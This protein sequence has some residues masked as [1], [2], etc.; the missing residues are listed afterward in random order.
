MLVTNHFKLWCSLL[1]KK[2]IPTKC[3]YEVLSTKIEIRL[4]KAEPVQWASLEFSS[5]NLAVQRVNVSSG[6]CGVKYALVIILNHSVL[7]AKKSSLF[8]FQFE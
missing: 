6:M 1:H 8:L 4:T 2:I 5:E 3:R 7:I